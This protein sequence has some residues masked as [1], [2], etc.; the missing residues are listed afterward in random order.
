MPVF[1]KLPFKC[2]ECGFEGRQDRAELDE[3]ATAPCPSCGRRLGF[4]EGD[5]LARSA[6]DTV[7][8]FKQATARLG[9]KPGRR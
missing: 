4:E 3:K 9:F 1:E 2:P 6:A 7:E 8:R 5:I